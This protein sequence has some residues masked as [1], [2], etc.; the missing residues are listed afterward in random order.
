MNVFKNKAISIDLSEALSYLRVKRFSQILSVEEWKESV[1]IW[2]GFIEKYKP[3]LLLVD[4]SSLRF[5]I[6]PDLQVWLH[7]N[8]IQVA[9]ENGMKKVALINNND[10]F[11]QTA[12][13]Q[14]LEKEHAR[15]V[16]NINYF[17]DIKSA[18][19]W[20]FDRK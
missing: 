17:S 8:L 3:V 18:E 19:N 20:L 14:T 7:D 15:F 2:A 1:L 6:T 16:V 5:F 13:E 9:I 10:L 12:V 11:V 4:E